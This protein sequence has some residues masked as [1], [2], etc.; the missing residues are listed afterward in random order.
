[1]NTCADLS[2]S[3]IA[4]MQYLGINI[5]DLIILVILMFYGYEG[6]ILGFVSSFTDLLSF[7][8]SFIIALKFY[9]VF[10][11]FLGNTFG[12][13]AGFARAISFFIVSI[14]SEIILTFI[15]RRLRIFFPSSFYIRPNSFFAKLNRFFGIFPGLVSAFIILA[16]LLSV[17]ISLPS[18]PFLKSTVISSR[19]GNNLV[20]HAGFVEARLNDIFGGALDETMNFLTVKPSG[21]ETINLHFSVVNPSTDLVSEQEMLILVN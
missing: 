17:I 18:S 1:M 5:L 8:L 3:V 6:Y 21:N 15:F 20:S 4:F 7:V 11:L 10:G 13:A 14:T 19:I 12:I 2:S 9:S 16:F